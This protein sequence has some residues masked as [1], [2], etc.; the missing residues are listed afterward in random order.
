MAL[1]FALHNEYRSTYSKKSIHISRGLDHTELFDQVPSQI[2]DFLVTLLCRGG[3]L[4]YGVT[5]DVDRNGYNR[6][7]AYRWYPQ[8]LFTTLLL[9]S[10]AIL[11]DIFKMLFP[12][13]CFHI[14]R[15]PGKQSARTK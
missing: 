9:V 15:M 7:P 14:L 12:K 5:V 13:K 3:G 1:L 8:S 4:V 11:F 2:G 10:G 6:L